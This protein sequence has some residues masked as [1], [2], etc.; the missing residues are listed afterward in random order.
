MNEIILN[1]PFTF[2][3]IAITLIQNYILFKLLKLAVVFFYNNIFHNIIMS[4]I[5]VWSILLGLNQTA[6]FTRNNLIYI[7][8]VRL[9]YIFMV[10]TIITAINSV[11]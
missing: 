2:F 8:T 3:G 11:I 7:Y 10:H 5:G 6:I 4:F 9:I 1:F